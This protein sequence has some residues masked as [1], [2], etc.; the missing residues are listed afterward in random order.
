M[1]T[2]VDA[3]LVHTHKGGRQGGWGGGR[4]SAAGGSLEGGLA[5][6]GLD[7]I[8]VSLVA[9]GGT[10][11]HQAQHGFKVAI[12]RRGL[13][14]CPGLGVADVGVCRSQ[15]QSLHCIIVT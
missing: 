11:L 10:V 2:E 12:G 1:G 7:D 9:P 15:Q 4:N 8:A 14:C 3:G 6:Q 13:H 5:A